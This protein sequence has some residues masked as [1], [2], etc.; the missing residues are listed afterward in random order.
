MKVVALTWARYRN[1]KERHRVEVS[2]ITIII[3]R[4]G[5]GKSVISRLLLL[6]A[7]GTNEHALDCLDLMAG[8]VQHATSY[9]D[10]VHLQSRQSFGLGAEVESAGKRYEFET[11]LRYVSELRRVTVEGFSLTINNNKLLDIALLNDEE[12]MASRPKYRMNVE[13]VVS[14]VPVNFVGRLPLVENCDADFCSSV[15][16]ALA[17]IRGALARYSYLGPIR[18]D[19]TSLGRAPTQPVRYLGP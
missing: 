9:R 7:S 14:I 6:L 12:L 5:S 15:T 2:P 17:I 3:G 4:N 10:L 18:M 16:H 13:G 19:A 11:S 8:G 1:F